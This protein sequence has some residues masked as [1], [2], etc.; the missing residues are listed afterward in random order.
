MG[1]G[2]TACPVKAKTSPLYQAKGYFKIQGTNNR[3]PRPIPSS[4]KERFFLEIISSGTGPNPWYVLYPPTHTNA[5]LAF[6]DKAFDKPL[7][8]YVPAQRR[9][10]LPLDVSIG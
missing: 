5:S 9:I 8:I 2:I 3:I 6:G 10:S 1:N 7:R 4:A